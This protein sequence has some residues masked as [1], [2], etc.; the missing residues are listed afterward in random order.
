MAEL[1][2]PVSKDNTRKT[3]G[4]KYTLVPTILHYSICQ[5]HCIQGHVCRCLLNLLSSYNK[6]SGYLQYI[7]KLVTRI[8]ISSV[9]MNIFIFTDSF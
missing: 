8:D 1:S 4:E 3:P 7:I 5:L 6:L 2:L 9:L